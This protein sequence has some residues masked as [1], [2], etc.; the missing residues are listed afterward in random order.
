MK[1]MKKNIYI[2]NLIVI[3]LLFIFS[4]CEKDK[5]K[6]IYDG[7]TVVEFKNVYLEMQNL[8]G[9]STINSFGIIASENTSLTS[10]TVRA[11]S[12]GTDSIRVQLVGPQLTQATT[13]NYQ[14]SGDATEG[15]DYFVT[16]A[17]GNNI[18]GGNLS[19]PARRSHGNI[20]LAIN[21]AA[22]LTLGAD[23][24]SITLTGTQDGSIKASK[25]YATFTYIIRP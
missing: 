24:V 25:N 2:F 20:Y 4:A 23:T 7:P 16:D 17:A 5:L 14:I 9:A 3:G 12:I 22:A 11:A 18:S 19:I 10:L 21:P 6:L 15:Q 13:I 8:L 1:H